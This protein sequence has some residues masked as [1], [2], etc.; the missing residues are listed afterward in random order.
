MSAVTALLGTKALVA[1]AT[2]KAAGAGRF[3][4]EELAAGVDETHH[5][6]PGYDVQILLRWGDRIFADAPAFDPS[7]QSS[8]AQL[9]Q[10][11]Y[12]NDYVG[13]IPL[14]AD[15]AHGLL[16][17]N[18]EYTSEEVM[19][20][21][22]GR[23]DRIGFAGMTEELVGIEMAAHGGT[24]VEIARGA[25]GRWAPV[26][27]SPYNRRITPLTTAIALDGP[28]AG[29]HRLKTAADPSGREVVGTVNNCAGGI[30]PWGT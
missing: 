21:G 24:V 28:A 20:P 9:R 30:T 10:F 2:A 25:D 7:R 13:F 6:A 29:H 18:H 17:V 8:V 14:G 15:G 3:A 19:F 23:Q 16:C 11:G 1:P 5:V 27:A 12:N 22:L 4:F 26:L